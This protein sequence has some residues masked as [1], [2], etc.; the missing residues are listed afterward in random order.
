MSVRVDPDQLGGALD[1][2]C[3]VTRTVT[4][5]DT[6]ITAKAIGHPRGVV[7]GSSDRQP[8]VFHPSCQD[9]ADLPLAEPVAEMGNPRCARIL[10]DK[11]VAG[12]RPLLYLA[13]ALQTAPESLGN[14]A[15][16]RQGASAV[17]WIRA[18]RL[19]RGPA[20]IADLRSDHP[21]GEVRIGT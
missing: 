20:L 2:V 14:F 4:T 19:P 7:T 10:V 18:H 15:L 1:A 6:G 3:R 13:Q 8:I 5:R 21:T 16:S 12:R 17:V 9:I 11:P